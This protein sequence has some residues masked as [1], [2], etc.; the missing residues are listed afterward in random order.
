MTTAF[1]L[2]GGS[3]LGAVQTGM[4]EVLSAAGIEPDLIVGS[5]VGAL[6]GA[7]LASHPGREGAELLRELWL[8]VRRRDVFPF[9]PLRIMNGVLGRA[10]HTVSSA[11]LARWLSV[12][13]PFFA[14][15]Q[16][17]LPLHVV[18][19]D[20]L[21]GTPVVLSSGDAI[22]ALLASCAIPGVFPPVEIGG[23]LLVDG[24]ISANSPVSQAVALGADTVY[25]LPTVSDEGGERPRSAPAV[26]FQA[27]SHVLGQA[28]QAE[29]RAN[30]G[31]CT[32]FV[33][34]A[35]VAAGVSP[36]DFR[37]SLK[38]M[39]M[40]RKTTLVWLRARRPVPAI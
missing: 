11:P 6:N 21:T 31:R 15:E 13:A 3:S 22:E 20:L 28:S 33:V 4:V 40:A 38:L 9:S 34:P 12:R 36:F 10:D 25:L 37:H 14:L 35:P 1:V 7:W 18:A 32:L 8:S 29:V 2:S 5:S 19:T 27:V 30:A 24:G 16:A 39:D 17:P 26:A 23:R